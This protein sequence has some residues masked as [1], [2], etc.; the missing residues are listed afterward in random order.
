MEYSVPE[1]LRVPLEELCLHIM[2]RFVLHFY[3][4]LSYLGDAT[5]RFTVTVYYLRLL[6]CSYLVLFCILP[7]QK[8]DLGSP[9]EFLA[10]ALDPP[11]LQVI[12]NAM[13]L[14]RKIGACELTQ[15]NLTPLGQHLAALPV[16]VKI[17]K[18]LIFGAIFGCLDAVVSRIVFALF[19]N[20]CRH[21]DWLM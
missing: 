20:C 11:Q 14:L 17:G 19:I 2:V 6:F 18:M 4:L 10:K 8:C 3:I 5:C 21:T 7:L 13:N 15:P 12:S 9:E 1:I 16:N